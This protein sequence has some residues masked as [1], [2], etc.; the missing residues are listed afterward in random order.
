MDQIQLL[1]LPGSLFM[2]W[3]NLVY[4]S[5]STESHDNS[6][7]LLTY[8]SKSLE[9]VWS[10]WKRRPTSDDSGLH[11]CWDPRPLTYLPEEEPED[12]DQDEELEDEDEESSPSWRPLSKTIFFSK[13]WMSIWGSLSRKISI[14]TNSTGSSPSSTLF[15][16]TKSKIPPL[17]FRLLIPMTACA[18]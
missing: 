10:W 18:L 12:E 16:S 6:I 3:L 2:N 9:L 1:S 15:H 14:G 13:N 5:I 8:I 17:L 4:F 7:G 11:P